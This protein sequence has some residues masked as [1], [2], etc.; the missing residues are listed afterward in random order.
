MYVL[1]ERSLERERRL[2]QFLRV[3]CCVCRLCWRTRNTDGRDKDVCGHPIRE[4]RSAATQR[5]VH[6]AQITEIRYKAPCETRPGVLGLICMR[7]CKYLMQ[8]EEI[9][10]F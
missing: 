7:S 6:G 10:F 2:C 8:R 9:D 4:V 5:Q 1:P 3:F